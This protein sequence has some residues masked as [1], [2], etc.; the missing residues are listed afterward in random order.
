MQTL[1]TFK[2]LIGFRDGNINDVNTVLTETPSGNSVVW[3]APENPVN[4]EIVRYVIVVNE[5]GNVIH[6]QEYIVM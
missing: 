4:G 3:V 1:E 2:K 6:K 5:G